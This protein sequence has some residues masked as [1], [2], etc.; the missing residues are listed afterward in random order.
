MNSVDNNFKNIKFE[1]SWWIINSC[2]KEDINCIPISKI[3]FN[4][5]A[6]ILQQKFCLDFSW[7]TCN[8]WEQ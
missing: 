8:E 1:W 5:A 4:H 7:S 6:Q 2:I 3:I